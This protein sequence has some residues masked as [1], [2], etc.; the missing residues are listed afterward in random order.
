MEFVFVYAT[1]LCES[2]KAIITRVQ[3]NF[4]LPVHSLHDLWMR[5]LAK[6]LLC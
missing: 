6:D 5:G 3:N 2:A 1:P 4:T